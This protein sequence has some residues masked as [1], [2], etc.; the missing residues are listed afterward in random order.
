MKKR[1]EYLQI[2]C[3]LGLLA[4]ASVAMA[5]EAIE[6][7]KDYIPGREKPIPVSLSGFSGESQEVI[8]FDLTV[9]GFTFTSPETAQYNLSGSA[10]GN[11]VGRAQ[12]RINKPTSPRVCG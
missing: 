10:A 1:T 5:D 6:I 11:L 3:T 2:A 8:K 7:I 9:Q 4:F 12:D